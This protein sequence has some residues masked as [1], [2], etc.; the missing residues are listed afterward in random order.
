MRKLLVTYGTTDGHTRKIAEFIAATAEEDQG[1]SVSVA[2]AGDEGSERPEDYDAVIVA[3]S[4]HAGGYQRAVRRWTR[5]HAGFLGRVPCAFV[6]VCLGVLQTD[7][8][9]KDDLAGI[10][11]RFQAETGWQ[12][13]RVKLVA[14]ALPY[15]RYWFLKKWV[16][17]RIS[18]KAG[19][20]TDTTRD[21][22]YTDWSDLRTFVG[23]FLGAEAA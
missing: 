13:S 5:R 7:Q 15:T 16:M 11:G 14:G 23:D 3:A 10:L 17:R 22:E 9:A 1:C 2:R 18:A 4:V 8:K 6:S 19:G 12:P 21:Y 20:G